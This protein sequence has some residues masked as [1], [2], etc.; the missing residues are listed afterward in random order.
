MMNTLSRSIATHVLAAGLASA[1]AVYWCHRRPL[2]K[3]SPKAV[4][5]P[6]PGLPHP[7]QATA[8]EMA[9][10]AWL[11]PLYDDPSLEDADTAYPEWHDDAWREAHGW[12]GSDFIHSRTTKGPRILRYFHDRAQQMLIGAAVFGP[13]SESHAGCVHP[14][15]KSVPSYLSIYVYIYCSL[16]HRCCFF[17]K[18]KNVVLYL[19]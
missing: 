19:I 5:P 9:A 2:K 17:F 6:P 4:L 18:K 16:R 15:Q 12:R 8:D 11:A 13:N 7:S 14:S 10:A 3:Q 1:V